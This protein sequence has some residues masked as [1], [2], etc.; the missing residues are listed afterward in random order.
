MSAKQSASSCPAKIWALLLT[1]STETSEANWAIALCCID[2]S[3]W[4]WW[5]I[6]KGVT[7]A[8]R[9]ETSD[10]KR[11]PAMKNDQGP[12]YLGEVACLDVIKLRSVIPLEL[13]ERANW[14]TSREFVFEIWDILY[15]NGILNSAE[16]NF[17]SRQL[18][19]GF[20]RKARASS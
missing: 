6:V 7:G 4:T 20:G 12:I 16:H 11:V 5:N 15:D 9:T 2:N 13:G 19:T 10:S 18:V 1:Q 14:W 17:G 3:D 8:L